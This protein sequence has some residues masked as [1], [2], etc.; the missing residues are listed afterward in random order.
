M[1]F[2]YMVPILVQSLQIAAE[3]AHAAAGGNEQAVALTAGKHILAAGDAARAVQNEDGCKG[4]F[5][6]V[7]LAGSIHPVNREIGARQPFSPP[8]SDGSRWKVWPNI[9]QIS[10][11]KTEFIP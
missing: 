9:L 3:I 11:R 7:D 1:C 2:C 5:I 8:P 4:L 10:F 6:R